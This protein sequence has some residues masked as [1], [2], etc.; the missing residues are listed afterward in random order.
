MG[1]GRFSTIF[2]TLVVLTL[3][4]G[5]IASAGWGFGVGWGWEKSGLDLEQGYDLNTVTTVTGRIVSLGPDSDGKHI[6]AVIDGKGETFHAVLGPPWYWNEHGLPLKT[7]DTVTIRGAKAIGKDGKTYL[8]TQRIS[9]SATGEEANLRSD[10]GKPSWS[11]Q[12][13]SGSNRPASSGRRGGG[14]RHGR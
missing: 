12:S 8:L 3:L 13:R 10:T 14:G 11:G 2:T 9:N 5:G 4:Q 1:R 7:G 6:I